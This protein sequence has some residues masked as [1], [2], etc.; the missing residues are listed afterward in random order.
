VFNACWFLVADTTNH[1]MRGL[2]FLTD[3]LLILYLALRVLF[4]PRSA[5]YFT[6]TIHGHFALAKPPL[7]G[8]AYVE[9]LTARIKATVC[10]LFA[11]VFA[12]TVFAFKA[13]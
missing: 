3:C 4:H 12:L 11:V 2:F 5:S 8:N 7:Q 13:H 6:H 9:G 1:A 10:V